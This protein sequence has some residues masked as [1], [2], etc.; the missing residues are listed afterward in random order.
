MNH[1]IISLLVSIIFITE[2]CKNKQKDQLNEQTKVEEK[3]DF[4]E[5]TQVNLPHYTVAG[6]TLKGGVI[7]RS[8]YD[9][10]SKRNQSN[11]FINFYAAITSEPSK[12]LKELKS[13]AKDTFMRINDSLIYVSGLIAKNP[14]EYYLDGYIIDE[15]Y[16]PDTK[17]SMR[18]STIE[19]RVLYS[20][21]ARAKK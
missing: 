21:T 17:T 2:S 4:Q 16:H 6:D 13:I 5:I 7:Y 3:I 19:T 1:K 11:R 9:T 10:L 18:I 20:I 14:G 12:N 8:A 15:I